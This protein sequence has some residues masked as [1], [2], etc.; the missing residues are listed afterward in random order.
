MD[1]PLLLFLDTELMQAFF[2]NTRLITW[3]QEEAGHQ[4]QC[5]RS[6]PEYYSFIFTGSFWGEWYKIQNRDFGIILWLL[7]CYIVF[8]LWVNLA[9]MKIN[10]EL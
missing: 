9:A 2:S 10:N 1:L 8:S 4:Q 7:V 3:Q 5:Y 6:C